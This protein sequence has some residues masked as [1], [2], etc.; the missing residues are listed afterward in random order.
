MLTFVTFKW[1]SPRGYRSSFRG[2]HVNT[3]A[4]M[5]RRYYSKPHRFVCVTDDPTGI[6]TRRVEVVKLWSDFSDVPSPNGDRFPS[7]YRRLKL[8]SAEAAAIFGERI[9]QM[10]LDVVITGDL[11][12]LFDRGED[13]CAFGDTARNTHYNGSLIM[14]RT[15][16]RKEVWDSFDPIKSP[17]ITRAAGIVGSDQAWISYILGGDEKKW[18][19]ADGVYSWR[20]HLEPQRGLLPDNARVVIFH[21]RS[22][23]WDSAIR[24]SVP[25]V[26]EYY[27]GD[28]KVVA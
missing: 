7:C 14:L 24:D 26:R 10:D 8:F 5:V 3:A 2:S 28:E 22:D 25:W 1:K 11:V 16:T 4:A 18:G 27:R 9:V 17:K 20:C 12:P 19:P 6:D 21:G 15:G 23:P 13:F